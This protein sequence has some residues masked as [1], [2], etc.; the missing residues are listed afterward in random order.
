MNFTGPLLNAIF[1]LVFVIGL[2]LLTARGFRWWQKTRPGLSGF[3]PNPGKASRLSIVETL[4][5]DFKRKLL[6]VRRDD[7][8]HLLLCS[9]GQ[10]IVIETQIPIEP[11]PHAAKDTKNTTP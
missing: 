9:D 11:S 1:S 10:D 8:L 7:V 3:I 4:S 2:I 6:L 5:I